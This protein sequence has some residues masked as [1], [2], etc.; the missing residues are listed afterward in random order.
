MEMSTVTKLSDTNHLINDLWISLSN[1]DQFASR[2]ADLLN[3]VKHSSV[4]INNAQDAILQ[5]AFSTRRKCK[6]RL[7][8]LLS[9]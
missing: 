9:C 7:L 2:S 4:M 1:V 6:Q 5:S 8:L 3:W